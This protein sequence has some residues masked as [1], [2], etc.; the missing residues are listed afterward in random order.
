MNEHLTLY[1]LDALAEAGAAGSSP[2]LEGCGRCRA[3]LATMLAARD[4]FRTAVFPRTAP[5]IERRLKQRWWRPALPFVLAPA[6]ALGALILGL[7]LWPRAPV[8]RD[9]GI[10]GSA[11]V[12]VFAQHDGKVSA[13]QDGEMLEAGDALRFEIQPGGLPYLLVGS[14][15]AAGAAGIIFPADGAESGRIDP[16]GQFV[17]PGSAVLDKSVGP[18]RAFVFLSAQPISAADARVA[19]AAA[20]RG[21]AAAVRTTTRLQ[22][23]PAQAQ[24]SI[25]WEK[26]AP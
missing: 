21:G 23:V 2:H 24:L 25:L 4:C 26:K 13:V 20:A 22:S 8:E 11:T 5:E 12:R 19:M 15:D 18:E 9:L 3:E 14:V 1:E 7:A 17:L 16:V 10:K 6:L